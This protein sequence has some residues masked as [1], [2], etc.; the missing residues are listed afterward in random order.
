MA[1]R[2]SDTWE[3]STSET[4]SYNLIKGKKFQLGNFNEYQIIYE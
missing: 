1:F 4:I 2:E 3:F